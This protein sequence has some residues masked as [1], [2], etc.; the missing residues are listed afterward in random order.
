MR[1]LS[2]IM[3]ML[4]IGELGL[5]QPILYGLG[6]S[7]LPAEGTLLYRI[8]AGSAEVAEIGPLGHHFCSG[9]AYDPAGA[10]RTVCRDEEGFWRLGVIDARSGQAELAPEILEGLPNAVEVGIQDLEFRGSDG[11]LLLL[12]HETDCCFIPP[13]PTYRV[14]VRDPD[15]GALLHQ[16]LFDPGV[17]ISGWTA[18]PDQTILAFESSVLSTIDSNT[19]E[20]LG[21]G[22]LDLGDGASRDL[23]YLPDSGHF[24]TLGTQAVFLP[25]V[26]VF[27][28]F[29]IEISAPSP[30]PEQGSELPQLEID[31]RFRVPGTLRSII[32][33]QLPDEQE[34]ILPTLEAVDA[35]SPSSLQ[36]SLTLSNFSSTAGSAS[37]EFYSS[38]GEPV[39]PIDLMC[40]PLTTGPSGDPALVDLAPH[41]A[42][43]WT[44]NSADFGGWARVLTSAVAIVPEVE[45]SFL[46][47]A[48]GQCP[49]GVERVPSSAVLTTVE[50]AAVKPG[51]EFS[52]A[53]FITP[54]RESGFSIVNPSRL[55]TA[56]V[57]VTARRADGSSFDGNELLVEPGRRLSLLLFELLIRNKNF[58]VPPR[59]PTNYFG[60]VSFSSDIPIAVGGLQVLFPEGKWSNL[61]V[62][63]K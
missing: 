46:Q 57:I 8:D 9:L 52:A 4:W 44:L 23:V 27:E 19:A 41:E 15:D 17:P 53:G 63:S 16:A 14:E 25:P 51:R 58:V 45:I 22:D 30:Q 48:A 18:S 1:A 11:A 13:P 47:S 55:E 29:I 50:V 34:W 38:L 42:R 37:V 24:L 61:P 40:R 3:F 35:T 39:P 28:L 12:V 32:A 2:L 62:V 59:R 5:A 10:L 6:Q 56:H 33:A 36:S 60:E 20:T 7:P 43:R 49:P 26:T 21:L 31:S 54:A